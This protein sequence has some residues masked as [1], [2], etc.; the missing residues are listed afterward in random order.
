M[1]TS[2]KAQ[3]LLAGLFFSLITA[4]CGTLQGQF[5]DDFSDGDFTGNPVWAGDDAKFIINENGQLQLNDVDVGD[6]V[7]TTESRIIRNTEWR[8]WIRMPFAPSANNLAKIYLAADNADLRS[9]LNGY[10][11][12]FGEGGSNDAIE[13]F[14]QE[15]STTTSICR[16]VEGAIAASF[17]ASVKVVFTDNVWTLYSDMNGG[18]AFQEIASG[19]D[20]AAF[21]SAYFGVFCK[22]TK[23]NAA[24]FFFD[25]FYVGEIYVDRDPPELR[26]VEVVSENEIKITFSEAVTAESAQNVANYNVEPGSMRPA[27][28]VLEANSRSVSLQFSQTFELNQAYTLYI[29]NI[30]DLAGNV[31]PQLSGTFHWSKPAPYDILITEIMARNAPSVGLP[32]ASYVEIYNNTDFSINL[33]GWALIIGSSTKNFGDYDLEKGAYL[34][35]CH[36]NN[37]EALSEWGECYGFSSF[38]LTYGGTSL[39]LYSPEKDQIA[40]V[41]YSDAWYKDDLKKEAGWSLERI[42][43]S[44]HC[45]HYDNWQASV[46]PQGGT[47]GR[48][49]SVDGANI[50]T[51]T[52]ELLNVALLDEHSVLVKFNKSMNPETISKTEIWSAD[53]G[54]GNPIGALP[55]VPDYS[56]V[57]LTFS[58]SI[59]RYTVY[60]LTLEKSGVVD[61]AD[62]ALSGISEARF[63]M[64]ETISKFDVVVNEVM[65]SPNNVQYVELYNRSQYT[66]DIK[67]LRFVFEN[68]K[69]EQRV[70]ALPSYLLF[71]DG[72]ALLTKQAENVQ[73]NYYSE[74][75]NFVEIADFPTLA[76][77]TGTVRIAKAEDSTQIVDAMR[78]DSEMHT[79]IQTSTS[80][81]SLERI[82]PERHSGDETNWHSAAQTAGFGTPG[83]KNSQFD[84][85]V[86]DREIAIDPEVFTPDNDGVDDILNIRYRFD[87]PGYVAN[88]YIYDGSGKFVLRLANNVTVGTEGSFSWDGRNESGKIA[89]AGIY[90]IMVEVF[91]LQGKAKRYKKSGTLGARF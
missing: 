68:N 78:Y 52:P 26:S 60:T 74:V 7:L 27:N 91:N 20:A 36:N 47:P 10:F 54:L 12:Q 55:I 61:C 75:Y 38:S 42:D 64:P 77:T 58:K 69:G 5:V 14:R 29:N 59:E 15:G 56:S 17:N 33:N 3:N 50:E 44:N 63:A 1:K 24:K 89:N 83:Y 13:L 9:P 45:D 19:S 48:K 72:Y 57:M 79:P 4:F 16:G 11:L 22:Y 51:V 62:I 40:H 39:T 67:N 2:M 32:E 73:K 25:D 46:D 71:P 30:S 90:V 43:L 18:D 49:N 34:I 53:Y 84:D 37:V 23:S 82:S 65:F 66:F 21:E 86:S 35:L 81:I 88:V 31:A 85:G 8:F 80:G 87:E 6:A 41:R 28:A 70:C 76:T